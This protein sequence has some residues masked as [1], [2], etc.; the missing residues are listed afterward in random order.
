M[1]CFLNQIWFNT[2]WVMQVTKKADWPLETIDLFSIFLHQRYAL[3]LSIVL[4]AVKSSTMREKLRE[5]QSKMF[6]SVTLN[7]YTEI[8]LANRAW[9]LEERPGSHVQELSSYRH[10]NFMSCGEVLEASYWREGEV[11]SLRQIPYNLFCPLPVETKVTH[12]CGIK[13][14]PCFCPD[15]HL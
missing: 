2:L 8:S 10:L 15:P 3:C 5:L 7:S 14:V 4:T 1:W 6:S 9:I 13:K 11:L 12:S